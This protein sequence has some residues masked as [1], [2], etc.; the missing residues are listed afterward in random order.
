MN[1]AV[2]SQQY[3]LVLAGG[4]GKGGYEVGVWKAL[5]EYGIAQKTTVISGTSVGGLNAAL[6]A[7]APVKRIEDIWINEVPYELNSGE[8][9]EYKAIS[10]YGL[11]NIMDRL[12]FWPLRELDAPKVYVTCS[13]SWKGFVGKKTDLA[14]QGIKSFTKGLIDY[15]Y[16]F[17]LNETESKDEICATLLATSAFPGL[18]EPVRLGD[19]YFYS[20]GGAADNTPVE[21]VTWHETDIIFVVHLSCWSPDLQSGKWKGM[22][23]I[24]IVPSREMRWIGGMLDF[25]REW[26][27]SN[28]QLGY[29]D[30]VEIL[31][32]RGFYPVEDYW[33]D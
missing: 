22:K 16:R 9:G 10:Q 30:T 17:M 7:V 3:G 18:T 33:F 25:S 6:F 1:S 15:A 20:D 29:S 19:G 24:D 27:E 28:I 23:I 11:K 32:A 5:T 12:S 8:D 26:A 31:E 14:I 4:G 13:R 2:F 21:P